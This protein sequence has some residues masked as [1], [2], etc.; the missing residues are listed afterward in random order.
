MSNSHVQAQIGLQGLRRVRR[1]AT[2]DEKPLKVQ[3]RPL[4]NEPYDP[5]ADDVRAI[6]IEL[7]STLRKLFDQQPLYLEQIRH[8]K[9]SDFHVCSSVCLVSPS[10]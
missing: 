3:V 8:L 6:H 2:I 4:P 10:Q 1:M 7:V 5:E 9:A